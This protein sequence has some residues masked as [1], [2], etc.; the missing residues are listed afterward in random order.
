M[1]DLTLTRYAIVSDYL[2]NQ[3]DEEWQRLVERVKALE[4][5]HAEPAND[6][7][8]PVEIR[9]PTEAYNERRHGKPWI[10]RVVFTGDS[11]PDMD[12]GECV[13]GV[14]GAEGELRI[15]V[16]PGA[17]IRWGQ[18]DH[19]RPDRSPTWWGGRDSGRTRQAGRA[20]AG[21]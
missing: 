19:R 15:K 10:A 17:V 9:I 8:E 3:T 4:A 11:R 7:P 1:T 16:D 12:W 18:K 20:C 13:G 14:R 5:D 2:S 6:A 21:R